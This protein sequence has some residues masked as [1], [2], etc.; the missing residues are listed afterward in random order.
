MDSR[1]ETVMSEPTR[2]G[3]DKITFKGKGTGSLGKRGKKEK[4]KKWWKLGD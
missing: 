3:E 1:R 2:V 4:G